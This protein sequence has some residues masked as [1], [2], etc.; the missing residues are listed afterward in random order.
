MSLAARYPQAWELLI[1]VAV[2]LGSYVAARVVSSLIARGVERIARRTQTT[3]DDHLAGSFKRPLTWA[4]F[5]GGAYAATHRLPL[6]ASTLRWVDSAL[7]AGVVL[8]L[9]LALLQSFGLLLHWYVSQPR[10]AASS[11]IATEFGP[12]ISKVGKVFIAVV[13]VTVLLQH[14]GVN[15]QSLVVSLGVG[16]LAIGLAAQDTLAN[17]FGGFTLM[18]DRPFRVGDRIQLATGEVGDVEAIGMRATRIRTT[19]EMLLVVPNSALVKDRVINFTLPSR[20]LTTR[21]EVDVAYDSD[22]QAAL[23][24][25]AAAARAVPQVDHDR[26]PTGVVK[27]FGDGSVVLAL[28]FWVRDY[29]DQGAARSAVLAGI[30]ERLRAAGIARPLPARRVVG[31]AAAETPTE[32]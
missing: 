11:A 19:D 31:E 15:V 24:V 17:M 6:P 3:L 10:L 13:A 29:L 23:A 22:L 28:T 26:E 1:S 20:A 25:L 8:L 16:S 9:A 2:L 32:A 12:L 14:F 4:L 21:V 30:H 27:A 5:L 7:F 18:L